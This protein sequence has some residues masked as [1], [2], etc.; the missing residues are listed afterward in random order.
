M[1]ELFFINRMS[2]G[3][4]WRKRFN[5]TAYHVPAPVTVEK[6]SLVSFG[7][8]LVS[9]SQT[10]LDSSLTSPTSPATHT[11]HVRSLS[12][13]TTGPA[14]LSLPH[15][16]YLNFAT[17]LTVPAVV[18]PETYLSGQGKLELNLHATF[19]DLESRQFYGSTWIHPRPVDLRSNGDST[20]SEVPEAFTCTRNGR[21]I[22]VQFE[23]DFELVFHSPYAS[24]Y[25]VLVIEFVLTGNNLNP[26]FH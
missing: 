5:C 13:R 15:S 2:D 3:R 23:Q 18:V 19:F 12:R 20:T 4:E 26:I 25:S 9:Q 24:P 21:K 11:L 16:V 1:F 17:N 22:N 7:K 14:Y 8:S 10:T 6:N